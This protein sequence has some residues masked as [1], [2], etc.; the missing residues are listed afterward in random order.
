MS[1]CAQRWEELL[2][3]TNSAVAGDFSGLTATGRPISGYK[4]KRQGRTDPPTSSNIRPSSGVRRGTSS[5]QEVRRPRSVMSGRADS[6]RGGAR[7]EGVKR[8]LSNENQTWGCATQPDEGEWRGLGHQTE[9]PLSL[10]RQDNHKHTTRGT[11]TTTF[12]K[13]LLNKPAEQEEQEKV[14]HESNKSN[15]MGEQPRTE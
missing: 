2:V 3:T 14:L 10:N 4:Q 5:T 9:Q 13:N 6:S 1:Q 7:E 11:F 8:S 15:A 12:Y